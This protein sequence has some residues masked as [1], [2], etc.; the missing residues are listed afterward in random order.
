MLS[1]PG[2]RYDET[3]GRFDL[4]GGLTY[5]DPAAA[6]SGADA[7]FDSLTNQLRIDDATFRIFAVPARGT[8]GTIKV[9]QERRLKLKDVTYTTCAEGQNGWLLRA[10]KIDINRDTGMATARDARLEF[11]GVPILY[12]P[13]LAYPITNKRTSGFLLPALGRSDSRGL[14]FQIPYY[15]NLAPNYDATLTPRYMSQRGLELQSEFRYL[16]FRHDGEMEAEFLPNDDVNGENRY[17]FGW[18]HTSQL[19][20]GW[21]ATINARTVSDTRFFEDLGS[22]VSSTS[23]T[24]LEHVL[25]LEYF[26]DIWSVLA[27]FQDFETLDE[28]LSGTE[29]P[30]RRV[31]EVTAL[32]HVPDGVLGLDW[33]F[34]GDLSVFDRSTGVTGMRLHLSPEVSLPLDY[35]GLWIEPAVAVEHTAYNINNAGAGAADGPSRTTPIYSLDLGTVFERGARG[36][37]GW[38]QTLEPRMQYV[39]IPFRFQD[40]LP[41][42]DTIEPD[43]NMVQLFRKNR[44]IGS[45]ASATRTSSTSA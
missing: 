7:S 41:V 18:D 3:T 19:G 42:F 32:A 16:G 37:G 6:I 10:A 31:P 40:D 8:A 11:Q 15:L 25:N 17:L 13:W 35:R 20:A 28:A 2:A 38:L 34:T 39:H 30:Y 33:D 22:S 26:D 36:G 44:F 43:F 5:W 9:E 1:A 23:Q 29:K 45:T 12:S 27:R 14:E 24:H 4:E 21:R